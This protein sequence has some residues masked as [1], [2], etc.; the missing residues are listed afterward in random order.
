[1]LTQ[2][3]IVPRYMIFTEAEAE[4]NIIYLGMI[5]PSI[6]RNEIQQLFY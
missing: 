6:N 3:P 2:G 4:F 1:M 5:D